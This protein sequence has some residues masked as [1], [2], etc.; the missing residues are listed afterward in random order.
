MQ[1]KDFVHL[2]VHS[3]YSLL[4]GAI[5]LDRLISQVKHFGMNSVALTDHVNLFGVLE[6]YEKAKKEGVHPVV[7]CEVYYLTK[8]SRLDKSQKPRDD[9]LAHLLL[10]VENE[11]GYKNL[12]R[13][14]SSSYLEGFY[15]KPRLDKE[16][17]TQYSKG[18][19]ALSCCAKGE[20]PRRLV[21]GRLEDGR[22]AAQE[23]ARIFPERFYLELQDHR[24]VHEKMVNE[25]LLEIA[26]ALSL[27]LVATNNAHYL[28][29]ED[30]T[31][32]EALLCIQTGRRLKEEDRLSYEGDE[33]Y[34]KS[35]EEMCELFADHPE[36]LENTRKIADA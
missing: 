4:H 11:E 8:G 23:L 17:L 21:E 6:F 5:S 29:R 26:Q 22:A 1:A 16:I 9:T 2:H 10:L 12:C 25:G 30:R 24:L 36:A 28:K 14:I 35:P 32:H 27:P 15:Y 34:L 31:S 13:L 19:F 20:V 7:G 18:L 3:Q 33:F